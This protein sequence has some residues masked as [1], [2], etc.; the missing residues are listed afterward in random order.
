MLQRLAASVLAALLLAAGPHHA[1]S[2]QEDPDI[3]GLVQSAMAG[4]HRTAAH[5]ARDAA[6]HPAQTLAFFGWRP[7]MTVVEIWPSAG[8]YTEILAPITRADGI[9]YAANF[10]PTADRTPI[11]RKREHRKYMEKLE[12]RPAV[13]NHVVPT[14]L[15]IPE[16]TTIAP[17]GS[18]DMVLTFRNV[19]NWMKGDYAPAMFDTMARALRPGGVLGVVEHRAPPGTSVARMK[20]SGYVTEQHVIAL[21]RSAG[22]SLE[23]RSEINANPRDDHQHPAGVWSLPPTLR[24]CR[25]VTDNMRKE[26]RAR[27]LAI[28]ESDRMTLRFRKTP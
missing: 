16:R 13:Y 11:W 20:Q 7:E 17:P 8:W 18:A 10:A 6:R 12:R 15:S 21:A 19:H 4:D 23:A 14:P 22:L 2:A 27:Y 3:V 9:L 5:R 26:C 25:R 28:G 24:H 1:A